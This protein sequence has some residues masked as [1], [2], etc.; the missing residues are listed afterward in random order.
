MP[1]QQSPCQLFAALHC[2][3]GLLHENQEVKL[4]S[5]NWPGL[6]IKGGAAARSWRFRA[7]QLH[8][9]SLVTR[10][11]KSASAVLRAD[12]PQLERQRR[13][14]EFFPLKKKK[15][16]FGFLPVTRMPLLEPRGALPFLRLRSVGVWTALVLDI[17]TQRLIWKKIKIKI[18]CLLKEARKEGC[19]L[20]WSWA[21]ARVALIHLQ[22]LTKAR[23]E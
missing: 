16:I 9:G 14:S 19:R 18:K 11:R 7:G 3:T 12:P 2:N 23:R 13:F 4:P 10:S 6:Q 1:S 17:S 21:A 8:N 5:I 20:G 15:R 22:P